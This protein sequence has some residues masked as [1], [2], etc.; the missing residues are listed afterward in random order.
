MG[1][2]NEERF[3]K[4]FFLQHFNNREH[5]SVSKA[6]WTQ[7]CLVKNQLTFTGCFYIID[8]FSFRDEIWRL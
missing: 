3:F 8:F 7:L 4:I 5:Q 6:Y 1:E 2:K